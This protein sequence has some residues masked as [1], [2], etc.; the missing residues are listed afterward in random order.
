M[1]QTNKYYWAKRFPETK[2]EVVYL[3]SDGVVYRANMDTKFYVRYFY[4][5]SEEPIEE[6][7]IPLK[8]KDNHYYV[9]DIGNNYQE[10]GIYFESTNN[11]QIIGSKLGFGACAVNVLGGPF[12]IEEL[13]EFKP[14]T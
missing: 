6:P 13:V 8:L 4:W 7:K 1:R 10:V 14:I 5:V 12:T 3:D 9:I 11:F 2:P